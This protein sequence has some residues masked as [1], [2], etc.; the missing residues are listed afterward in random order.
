[1]PG[2]PRPA[3]HF[4]QPRMGRNLVLVFHFLVAFVHSEI[5]ET[6]FIANGIPF[7]EKKKREQAFFFFF[8]FLET[9]YFV[10]GTSSIKEIHIYCIHQSLQCLH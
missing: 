2:A 1:M 6:H 3:S 4:A 10:L 8:F 5:T 7:Q 9:N